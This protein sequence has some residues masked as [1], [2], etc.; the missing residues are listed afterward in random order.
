M[1]LF[2]GSIIS[3]LVKLP[4][5]YDHFIEHK[6]LDKNVNVIAF[7]S[8]HYLGKDI[9]DNDHE[10]DM[11]LPFKTS[12][13]QPIFQLAFESQNPITEKLKFTSTQNQWPDR[14]R[15]NLVQSSLSSLFR[16]PRNA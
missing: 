8:M 2:D 3:Q 11:S 15:F 13:Y 16:P 1:L 14:S 9:Q 5:L 12:H 6:S 4:K 7:I 10:K